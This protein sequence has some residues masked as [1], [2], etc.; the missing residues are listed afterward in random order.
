MSATA[1]SCADFC[2]GARQGRDIEGRY[3][4]LACRSIPDLERLGLTRSGIAQ[5]ALSGRHN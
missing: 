3:N 5:A 4:E 1:P 2:G